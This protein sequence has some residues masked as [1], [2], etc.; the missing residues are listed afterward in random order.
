MPYYINVL[1]I[2]MSSNERLDRNEQI[3]FDGWIER[4]LSTCPRET[5]NLLCEILCLVVRNCQVQGYT[6]HP[7]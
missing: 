6:N 3:F 4:Y 5:F 2:I 7:S 1:E